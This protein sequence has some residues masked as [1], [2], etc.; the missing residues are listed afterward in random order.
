MPARVGT[1]NDWVSVAC[2]KSHF[3]A[4]KADGTLWAWGGNKSGQ[5]GDGTAVDRALPVR[6]GGADRWQTFAA[7][8]EHSVAI[9]ADG[10][11]WSW[12]RNGDG[13]LGDRT[14]IDRKSPTRI[15]TDND[16]TAVVARQRGSAA[17]RAD[18]TIWGWGGLNSVRAVVPS[19]VGTGHDWV[20][21]TAEGAGIRSD[22]TRSTWDA[23]S[24]SGENRQTPGSELRWKALHEAP[25]H[26]IGIRDD[27]TLWAWGSNGVGQ[28]GD[29][30]TLDRKAPERIGTDN[31]W[32]DIFGEGVAIRADGTVWAWGRRYNAVRESPARI[33][34]DNDWLA[35]AAGDGHAL[36][37][38]GDGTLWGWGENRAGQVGDGTKE[39]RDRPVRIGD[40]ANWAAVSAR[41][42]QSLA[43]RADGTL[44]AWG[45][46]A[47]RVRPTQVGE[48]AG[49][50]AVR[51]GEHAAIAI[52]ADGTLWAWGSLAYGL[53]S[54][55]N[56][57]VPVG[58]ADE[59]MWPL[60]VERR[61]HG[62]PEPWR[63]D[64]RS[65]AGGSRW[66]SVSE[67]ERMRAA[68]RADG[69]LWLLRRE[70]GVP[71]AIG[72]DG[73]WRAVSVG[74][75]HALALRRE[76]SLRGFGWNESGELGERTPGKW[77]ESLPVAPGWRWKAV[78]AGNRRSFGIRDDGTLWGWGE[79]SGGRLGCGAMP[80]VEIGTLYPFPSE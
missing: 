77:A 79:N 71:E 53:K 54:A 60:A 47:E 22:G 4:R 65:W 5:A 20:R 68:V 55:R 73:E 33:G 48:D 34:N 38:R 40:A 32:A 80:P 67:G 18:G 52:R 49:W 39:P 31:D 17:L 36:A 42:D 30:T 37:I 69:T 41:G 26:T 57:P 76:G 63:F 21:I 24:N 6:V 15:G 64:P 35:V 56:T 78:A 25:D 10:T 43:L 7:G 9:R 11:L 44:W 45:S 16:W 3:L 13:E 70:D 74:A 2:G 23:W 28:L 51:A 50:T 46:L 14:R 12:G 58:P 72:T 59:W 29:G 19:L 66:L 1:D 62:R 61:P 8:E 75:G 27:G